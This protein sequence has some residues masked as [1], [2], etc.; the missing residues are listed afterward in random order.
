MKRYFIIIVL[1]SFCIEAKTQIDNFQ[2]GVW[3]FSYDSASAGHH[4][5]INTTIGNSTEF[6]QLFKEYGFN[7]I[8]IEWQLM[9]NFKNMHYASSNPSKT[10]LDRADSLGMKII[11]NCPDIFVYWNDTMYYHDSLYSTYNATNSLNALNYY[12]N[13]PAVVGISVTDEPHHVHFAD[14]GRYFADIKN[15]DST[16]FRLANLKSA[17]ANDTI[18]GYPGMDLSYTYPHYVQDFITTTHPNVLSF[19]AYPIYL[20]HSYGYVNDTALWPG[21]FYFNF[22]VIARAAEQNNIPFVYIPTFLRT[23]RDDQHIVEQKNVEELRYVLYSGLMH[24]AKGL[25]YWHAG[26]NYCVWNCLEENAKLFVKSLNQS[27]LN[28]E[29]ILLSLHYKDSYHVNPISTIFSTCQHC[30]NYIL[31]HMLWPAFGND[32]YTQAI[33]DDLY[34]IVAAVGGSIDSLAVSY[35]HDNNGGKYFWIDNKSLHSTENITLNLKSNC[36]IVDVMND[37]KCPQGGSVCVQLLPGEAKLFRAFF[38]GASDTISS[39]VTWSQKRVQGQNL[40]VDSLSTLT[41][42]DT[43]FM[44][45]NARLIVRPGGKLV[46][47]GGTLTSA[48][49]GEMWQGIEVVGDRTKRQL[50]QF[51]GKVELR[52]GAKIENAICGIRTGL[53]VNLVDVATTGGII[54]ADSA[55]FTN[56]RRAVEVNSYTNHSPAGTVTDNVCS[57]ERC[58]FTVDSSNLFAANGTAF[59]EHVK[60]WDVRGV[61]FRGCTFQNRTVSPVSNGRGVYAEDAGVKVGTACASYLPT[62]DCECHDNPRK[63]VFSGFTTAIEVNTTGNPHA[64]EVDEARFGNNGTGVKINGNQFVTVTRC[65]FDLENSP[66]LT[67]NRCGLCLDNCT[68]YHVEENNFHKQSVPVQS[69]RR[70][71]DGIVVNNSNGQPNELYRNMFTH[72]SD[73]IY[74]MGNNSSSRSGLVMTCNTFSS[75]RYDI[76]VSAGATVWQSQGGNVG[77]DNSFDHT[78]ASSFYNAGSQNVLYAY[79]NGDISHV[80]YN[81]YN[82]VTYDL[83]SANGCEPNLCYDGS[84]PRSLSQFQSD[85]DADDYFNAVRTLMSD[86]VLNLNELEQWHTAA[87]PIADP[88][89]LTETRFMEGYAETFSENAENAEMANYAEFHALKLALRD[90]GA[91]NVGTA[92]ANNYSPLQTGHPDINWYALTP[93]QIAQLQTIAERNT[94]RASVMAKGVLCFFFG[95]CY[96]DELAAG[97]FEA[98]MDDADTTGAHTK[99]AAMSA[100][101]EAALTVYPNPAGDLLHIELTNGVGI[102]SVALYDLQGRVVTGTHAGAPQPGTTT[103]VNLRNVPAGVYLLRVRDAEGKEY[104]RKIVKK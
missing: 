102:A 83:S 15:Y 56:N 6:Y 14:V 53:G 40:V 100:V 69:E 96:E 51:Q 7:T 70:R 81:P 103:T 95:I 104:M 87:L 90:N 66:L 75:D 91:D 50:A 61:K 67:A 77:A 89:S 88:Y 16:L 42:T 35:L 30:D 11:L 38:T 64:V 79:S 86:T 18:L 20:Y 43:L 4:A 72:L 44:A 76:F 41:I 33:F 32:T 1:F 71:V 92:E 97:V 23:K 57:F 28:H 22:D 73:G 25:N 55:Y 10:F 8:Q 49:P 31:S 54:L 3:S 98:G 48:C 46:I 17:D 78:I 9:P 84:V 82:I 2:I 39:S 19:D 21:S 12:G 45:N 59:T 27:I 29:D 93:A 63:S 47:D 94:G 80:P 52:N 101:D 85:M 13:H 26:G 37:Q 34:P 62:I 68:G 5:G 58:T 65:D 60:L 36:T 99:R 74:V 24:G